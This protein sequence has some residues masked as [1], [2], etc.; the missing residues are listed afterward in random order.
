MKNLLAEKKKKK[1]ELHLSKAAGKPE[2]KWMGK[3]V[4]S[5]AGAVKAQSVRTVQGTHYGEEDTL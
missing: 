3:A 1:K 2:S 5:K 4:G